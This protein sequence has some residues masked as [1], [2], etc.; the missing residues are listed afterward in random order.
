MHS[1]LS[2][3]IDTTDWVMARYTRGRRPTLTLSPHADVVF[4]F[5]TFCHQP[6]LLCPLCKKLFLLLSWSFAA[7]RRRYR[8]RKPMFVFRV[9]SI[10][11]TVFIESPTPPH[12]VM[13]G[14]G[15][16]AFSR[17]AVSRLHQQLR[18]QEIISALVPS[19]WGIG[20]GSSLAVL[21]MVS[22]SCSGSFPIR[23][24]IQTNKQKGKKACHCASHERK[25][26]INQ[27]NTNVLTCYWV[28]LHLTRENPIPTQGLTKGSFD[29][30]ERRWLVP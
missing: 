2:K 10:H 9:T 4:F 5:F 3:G 18:L 6:G 30:A 8:D 22:W 29:S 16:D 1:C 21:S 17:T 20:H 7:L 12:T 15:K 24:M 28:S 19:N 26:A 11:W 25:A 14:R 27:R 13:D 23:G